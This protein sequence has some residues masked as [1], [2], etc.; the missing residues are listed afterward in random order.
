M[1]FSL[2]WWLCLLRKKSRN[3]REMWY[4][5]FVAKSLCCWVE[6]LCPETRCSSVRA[7]V[8][9]RHWLSLALPKLVPCLHLPPSLAVLCY[10][11]CLHFTVVTL[12]KKASGLVRYLCRSDMDGGQCER[13]LL[14]CCV[15]MN[16]A[17]WL[18]SHM[19]S[20]CFF[21]FFVFFFFAQFGFKEALHVLM[22]ANLKSV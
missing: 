9:G 5:T 3:K 18:C 17:T 14:G 12:K 4:E 16:I 1:S 7:S 22:S 6:I 10:A 21:V 15:F 11:F 2:S 8:C 19:F 13:K 20:I